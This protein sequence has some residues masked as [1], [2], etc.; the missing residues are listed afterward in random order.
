MTD[1]E[2]YIFFKILCE[3]LKCKDCYIA[4]KSPDGCCPCYKDKYDNS[5]KRLAFELAKEH[6]EEIKSEPMKA[7]LKYFLKA[8][9]L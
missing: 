4:D 7:Y 8:G 5:D 9:V 3:G 2:L 1:S 6:F